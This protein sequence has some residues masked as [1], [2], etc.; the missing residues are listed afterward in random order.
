MHERPE[1]LT[2][3]EARQASPRRLNF[4]V[5]V[6]SLLLAVVAAG[7]LYALFYGGEGRMSTP[8]PAPTQTT[9]PGP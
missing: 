4:R 7:V 3:T 1:V 6:T 8:D 2:P 9:A 5:L